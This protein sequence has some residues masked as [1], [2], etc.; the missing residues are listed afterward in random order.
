MAPPLATV[1]RRGAV[2][3]WHR[4][5]A[6]DDPAY[7]GKS[8]PKFIVML[9]GSAQDD[10]LFYILASSEKPRHANPLFLHDL[11][12][13]PAGTYAFFD[14]PTIIDAS[15]AGSREIARETFEVLYQTGEIGHVGHLSA[16]DIAALRAT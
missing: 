8:K 11:L 9:S 7:T 2:F 1:L 15:T 14:Q 13:I 16:T 4:Y 5:Q 12:Q 10:P 3:I 6:L